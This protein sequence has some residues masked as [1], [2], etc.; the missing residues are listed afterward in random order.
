MPVDKITK[1]PYLGKM[2]GLG[3]KR[4]HE[5]KAKNGVKEVWS[6]RK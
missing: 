2:K 4:K 6:W 1:K 5:N 3:K